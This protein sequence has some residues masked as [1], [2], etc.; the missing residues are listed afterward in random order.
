[1][2]PPRTRFSRH[3]TSVSAATRVPFC[4]ALLGLFFALVGRAGGETPRFTPPAFAEGDRQTRAQAALPEVDRLFRE[5]AV[6]KHV[7]GL[8]YG[9]VVDGQLIRSGALGLANVGEKI[10]AALDTRFRI[11]SM[12]K[13]FIG[14][15]LLKLRDAGRL[16]LDDRIDRHLPELRRL[17]LPTADAPPLTIRHLLT[18]TGGLPEDNPWG[19]G[20]LAI[21]RE[22]LK[23][24]VAAGLSFSNPPGQGF[25]Y[26]NLGFV[27]LG[28]VITHAAGQPFQKYITR[29]LL[30][31]L[32]MKDTVWE[33]ADVPPTKLALGYRWEDEQWRVE[34]MA[35]DGE[36]AA[37]GG[38]LTTLADFARYV[39]FH[40]DAWPPRDDPERGPVRRASVREMHQP[41]VVTGLDPK[42][43]LRD[44]KTPNPRVDAYSYG[45]GWRLDSRG[46][47]Q[48]GHS[49]GLPGFGSRF[50]FCP[51]HGVGIIAFANRT[52]EAL[53]TPTADALE[54]LL[55]L[56]RLEARVQAPPAIL[57]TRQRQVVELLRTWDE[58]LGAQILAGNFYLDRSRERWKSLAGQALEALGQI[59]SVGPLRP[60]NQ[61][62]GTF[63]LQGE[64]GR[65]GVKFTLTP[66]VPPRVQELELKPGGTP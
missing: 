36:G 30:Q 55:E 31:P 28:Q 42:A 18:M 49:G 5:Y 29:E 37:C 23:K 27:L 40:L 15:A 20:Q 57:E 58:A 47:V 46:I 65:L 39:A 59:T 61:L 24:F 2:F 4:L 41:A 66:E 6:E 34:L 56:G 3:D 22:A 45:L 14:L 11:A 43:T 10:P 1:M 63:T 13:S 62:R 44:R 17:R 32:G 21:S 9:V 33:Y 7:P 52:Y 60:E 50:R 8:V 19:D 51:D 53:G 35:H 16:Q 48:L 25:E 64:K 38:L 54:L 12:T 26:S